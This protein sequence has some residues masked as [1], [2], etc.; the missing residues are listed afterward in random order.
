MAE[1][2]RPASGTGVAAACAVGKELHFGQMI[3]RR[4]FH[5]QETATKRVNG[6]QAQGLRPQGLGETWGLFRLRFGHFML[7]QAMDVVEAAL[8][9]LMEA[10]GQGRFQSRLGL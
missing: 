2:E 10:G 9:E 7:R 6:C 1:D 4:V 3:G 5:T 8:G